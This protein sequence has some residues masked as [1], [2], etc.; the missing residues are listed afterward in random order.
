MPLSEKTVSFLFENRVVD[1]KTWFTEHRAEYDSLVLDPIRELVTLLK[2]TM[3]SIDPQLI[4]EPKVGRSIS[5]IYRD[6]RF[7]ND[8]STFRDIMWCVFSRDKK[9]YDGLP[10]YW[11][12]FSPKG[13]RYGCGYYQASGESMQAL[14]SLILNDDKSFKAALKAYK[15]QSVFQMEGMKYKRSR[16]PEQ[17][18]EKREWLDQKSLGFITDST[19]FDLLFSDG[20]SDK[21]AQDFML[22]TPMYDFMMSAE[23]RVIRR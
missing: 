14:R 11:F 10:C 13:F 7:S 1:S 6:T 2:P 12:E 9:L 17:T 8:K 21:L 4:C 23:A 19:D 15:K 5:R 22:L 20:L 18:E 16:Y 3:L